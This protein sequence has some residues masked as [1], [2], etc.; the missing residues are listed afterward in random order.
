MAPPARLHAAQPD[1]HDEA[2][3]HRFRGG[4]QGQEGEGIGVEGGHRGTSPAFSATQS[5]NPEACSS[6]GTTEPLGPE[7]RPARG[8]RGVPL[9]IPTMACTARPDGV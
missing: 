1:Q 2:E 6:S 8:I 4:D 5:P 7:L 9:S 3:Q